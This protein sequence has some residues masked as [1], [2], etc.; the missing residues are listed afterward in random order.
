MKFKLTFVRHF[1][2]FSFGDDYIDS[3]NL[4]NDGF[5]RGGGGGDVILIEQET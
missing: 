2:F 1:D 4:R 5:Q 3:N